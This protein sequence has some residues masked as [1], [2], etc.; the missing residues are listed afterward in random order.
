MSARSTLSVGESWTTN[1][2]RLAQQAEGNLVVHDADNR[3][4]RAPNT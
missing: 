1:R 4:A 3:P 2:I